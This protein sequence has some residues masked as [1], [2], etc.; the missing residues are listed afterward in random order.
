MSQQLPLFAP[1]TPKAPPYRL[2]WIKAPCDM[3][4][5]EWN[6]AVPNLLPFRYWTCWRGM[7]RATPTRFNV[8]AGA[9]SQGA[10]CAS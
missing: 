10:A 5:W 1:P 3:V 2:G 8:F 6:E 7:K 4:F 9:Y